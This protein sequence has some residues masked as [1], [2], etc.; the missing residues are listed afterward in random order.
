MEYYW[1]DATDNVVK[2]FKF[3]NKNMA[4]DNNNHQIKRTSIRLLCK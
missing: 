4:F 2:Q 1:Y 3:W